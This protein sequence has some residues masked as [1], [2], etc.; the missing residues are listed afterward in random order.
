MT[1]PNTSYLFR[2]LIKLSISPQIFGVCEVPVFDTVKSE[3]CDYV[4]K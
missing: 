1:V 4:C 2:C 3:V